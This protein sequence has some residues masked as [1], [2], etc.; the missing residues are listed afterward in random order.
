MIANSLSYVTRSHIT[1]AAQY[2]HPCATQYG[3]SVQ[4]KQ[5]QL[6]VQ[7]PLPDATFHQHNVWVPA[8]PYLTEEVCT[9]TFHQFTTARYVIST[10]L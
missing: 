5:V 4:Q 7:L 2:E 10:R 8:N 3:A 9:F 1:R 6:P